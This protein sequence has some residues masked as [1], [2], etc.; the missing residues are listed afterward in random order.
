[1]IT[2]KQVASALNDMVL[3]MGLIS[4]ALY[5]QSR[6]PARMANSLPIANSFLLC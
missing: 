1:M 6:H 3:Q 5:W 2:D 4:I